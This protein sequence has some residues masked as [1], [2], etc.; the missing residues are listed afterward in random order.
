MM[1]DRTLRPHDR[2]DMLEG[3]GF[4]MEVGAGQNG[5]GDNSLKPL[6]LIHLGLSNI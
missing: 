6:S 5:H 3:G 2:L 1:A 4:I